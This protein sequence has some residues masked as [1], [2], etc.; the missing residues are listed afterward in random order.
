[1]GAHDHRALF[2]DD[3][4]VLPGMGQTDVEVVAG[5]G[6]G[7]RL[8]AA[9]DEHPR[10]PLTTFHRRRRVW[11]IADIGE[12]HGGARLDPNARWPE[13][14][15]HVVGAHPDRVASRDDGPGGS[16]DGL[17]R[18]RPP[19]RAELPPAVPDEPPPPPIRYGVLCCHAIVFVLLSIAVNVPLIGEPM[20]A[21]WLPPV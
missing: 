3:L 14:V 11:K 7:D 15:L 8:R 9:F 21:A 19:Q 13:A 6:E 12:S 18:G 16:R 20:G 2:H 10:V 5:L 1:C 17:R 4:A